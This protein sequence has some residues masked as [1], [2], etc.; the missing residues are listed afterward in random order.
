M[1]EEEDTAPETEDVGSDYRHE[2]SS[3]SDEELQIEDSQGS[4]I[5]NKRTSVKANHKHCKSSSSKSKK[6]R[7][8]KEVPA[9]TNKKQHH[10]HKNNNNKMV[11]TRKKS[12]GSAK[13]A[14]ASKRSADEVDVSK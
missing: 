13:A 1:T 8:F 7:P 5:N 6:R 11:D 2:E 14:S 9:S 3:L 12:S 4:V 10:K